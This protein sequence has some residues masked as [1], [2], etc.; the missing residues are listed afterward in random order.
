[1]NLSS[2]RLIRNR[3]Q[4]IQFAQLIRKFAKAYQLRR[5]DVDRAE[6]LVKKARSLWECILSVA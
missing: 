4:A 6:E 3:Q 5:K 1:M 2:L